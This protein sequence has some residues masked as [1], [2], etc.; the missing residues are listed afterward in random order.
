MSIGPIGAAAAKYFMRNPSHMYA[1]GRAIP[2][3]AQAARAAT[4][5]GVAAL[6]RKRKR[7][8]TATRMR[9]YFKGDNDPAGNSQTARIVTNND[10]TASL[11]VKKRGRKRMSKYGMKRLK[12]FKRSVRKT[13]Y[14]KKAMNVTME[15]SNDWNLVSNLSLD[16]DDGYQEV[17]L[18]DAALQQ[19]KLM[20]G[21]GPEHGASTVDLPRIN[22]TNLENLGWV[23]NNLP[24]NQKKNANL[25]F[26][27][28]GSLK[29][30][31]NNPGENGTTQMD[32]DVYTCVA[33]QDITESAYKSP[34]L[35]MQACLTE[36]QIADG[37]VLLNQNFKGL[38]PFDVPQFGEYWSVLNVTRVRLLSGQRAQL[39]CTTKGIYDHEKWNGR[40]AKK[41]ITKGFLLIARPTRCYP[42][43]SAAFINCNICT[44]KVY[45]WKYLGNAGPANNVPLTAQH[46]LGSI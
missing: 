28:K 40:F 10:Q 32:Y 42:P 15:R 45:R 3:A 11:Y 34:G 30:N 25:A 36:C 41:G 16:D 35:A 29:L 26:Y 24:Q 23:S 1:V 4:F 5:M 7:G 21:L 31:I 12:K 22:S 33:A 38:T 13:V 19:R 9:K 8:K 39:F 37:Q 20:I 6:S 46:S 27:F 44:Q 14:G 18:N 17:E 2:Y 43:V